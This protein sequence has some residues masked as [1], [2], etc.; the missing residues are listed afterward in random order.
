MR[1]VTVPLGDRTYPILIGSGILGEIGPRARQLGLAGAI[2]L[3]QD[4]N[5]AATYGDIVRQSLE[6]SGYRV[7]PLTVP[8]G[9]GSKC[10]QQLGALY[11]AFAEARLDR[12][13][14]VVAVGGGVV[15]DLAGF[16]AASYLRGID[17]IQVPTTL[18]AQVDSS[19]GGKTGIDLEAGKNLVG[20]FHQ[21][22]LVLADLDTLATLPEREFV[23]GLAEVIKYG[24]IL[25]PEF[26]EYLELNRDAV[27]SHQP[28]TLAHLVARSCELKA[29][30]VGQD[31]RESGLRAILN[32]GHTIGHAVEATAGYGRYLHGEAV[33]I[34][35]IAAGKLSRMLAGLSEADAARIEALYRQYGCPVRL[36]EALD[37]PSLFRAMQLDKK[38]RGDELRFVL[39]RRIG[40]VYT[41][42]V[43]VAAVREALAAIAPDRNLA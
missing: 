15:G 11:D 22:R 37:E 43:P 6:A 13:S 14:A 29:E 35:T 10:L 16:A 8:P 40:E 23:A 12:R 30:V 5:V 7:A 3:V 39:A 28:E 24:I 32:Y 34:G 1:E 4:A 9:E 18:L 27:F 2:A 41:A 25:D 19:V 20:A 33:A 17:F 36:D 31:E 38:T 21:P 26:F 42:A